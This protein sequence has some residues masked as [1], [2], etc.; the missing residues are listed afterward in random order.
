M[1]RSLPTAWR[2]LLV[3]LCATLPYLA[4]LGHGFLNWDDPDYVGE[5]LV[6]APDG[7]TRIW[8]SFDT[9]Q[10]YPVVFS[11][12]WLEHR[13]WGGHPFGYH[14][15]SI[16]LH[17]LASLACLLCLQRLGASRGAALGVALLFA[18]YPTQAASVSWISERKN[19]LSG[20][21]GFASLALWFGAGGRS[22][23]ASIGLGLLAILSKATLVTLPVTIWLF[24]SRRV[25]ARRAALRVAPLVLLAIAISAL[26]LFREHGPRVVSDLPLLDR[27]WVAAASLSFHAGRLLWPFGVTPLYPRWPLEVARPIGIVAAVLLLGVV[28]ALWTRER[29]LRG[30]SVE[31]SQSELGAAHF[32]VAMI[33]TLGLAPFGYLEH[34]FVADHFLYWPC[35][36]LWWAFLEPLVQRISPAISGTARL[37]RQSAV[38]RPSL[39]A[40]AAY[41]L[42]C[43]A[44]CYRATLPYHDSDRFW[45]RVLEGNDRA[46]VA[47]QNRGESRA[48]EGRWSDAEADLRRALELRP[49]A[50]E[51]RFNLGYV[52]D[53]KGDRAA[54]MNEYRRALA[55]AAPVPDAA[56]NLARLE[57]LTARDLVAAG[58]SAE[59]MPHFAEARRLDPAQA[60]Y[61]AEAA[62]AASRLPPPVAPTP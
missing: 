48:Q 49:A 52:L 30:E 16:L 20:L 27:V 31:R 29:R 3:A 54:A 43:G 46:W 40:G 7:L 6:Q 18:L 32:G 9:A 42:L 12:L 37:S 61:A 39:V 58:K 14:L 57:F 2:I 38:A 62:K 11:V 53:R 60:V 59:A 22:R 19:L 55:G 10:V 33:P 28:A 17:A 44:L 50:V 41:L 21:F 5:P 45:S 4:T 34:S 51:A 47:W 26:T 35:W 56:I 24:D 15:D 36:G 25:G 8:T 13:I 1:R 23:V